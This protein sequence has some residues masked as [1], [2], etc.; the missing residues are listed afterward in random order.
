MDLSFITLWKSVMLAGLFSPWLTT[1]THCTPFLILN[2]REVHLFT[3]LCQNS[4]V[5]L[6][7]FSSYFRHARDVIPNYFT[8]DSFAHWGGGGVAWL[9]QLAPEFPH[10]TRESC[11]DEHGRCTASDMK[12]CF[13]VAH[14]AC[15]LYCEMKNGR[16]V[17]RFGQLVDYLTVEARARSQFGSCGIYD[18]KRGYGT[19][20]FLG[21]SRLLCQ[22][23]STNA[24]YPFT[25]DTI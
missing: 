24:S 2:N 13:L 12:P 19:G 3:S 14:L 10:K 16:V 11:C 7:S 9:S 18:G 4:Q 22:Y 6:S 5:L 8:H 23:H 21:T 25:S 20:F 1:A 15:P 17:P